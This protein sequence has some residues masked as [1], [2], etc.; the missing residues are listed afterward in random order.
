ML[1]KIIGQARRA[2]DDYN[3][4]ED[5]DKIAIGLSGG[6]DSLTLVRALHDLQMFYPKKFSIMAITIHPGSETFKTDK[7]EEFCA[8]F[9]I[10]YLSL[11]HI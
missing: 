5:G 4:I 6:K 1:Q 8:S 11:I 9:G 10:E 3:M 2:I 7:L